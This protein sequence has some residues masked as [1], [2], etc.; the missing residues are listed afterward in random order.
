MRHTF[1]TGMLLAAM[2]SLTALSSSGCQ[3]CR[4]FD[5]YA[6]VI[7]DIS[8]HECNAQ[9]FWTPKWDLTRIGKADWCGTK[10]RVCGGCQQ[11]C[12]EEG[13]YTPPCRCHPYPQAY[14]Y[15][16]PND[17]LQRGQWQDVPQNG[18]QA[19]AAVPAMPPSPAPMGVPAAPSAVLQPY[20]Q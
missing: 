18:P 13:C 17:A 19:P 16:Y 7:D 6:G 3:C 5:R 2:G 14:P 15:V 11:R 9:Y 12:N 10:C 20:D 1:L 8:D 4:L